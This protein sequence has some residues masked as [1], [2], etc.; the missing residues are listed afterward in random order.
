MQDHLRNRSRI[1][2]LAAFVACPSMLVA[3]SYGTAGVQ[4]AAVGQQSAQAEVWCQ[5]LE[6]EVPANLYAEMDCGSATGVARSAVADNRITNRFSL[7]DLFV[8][9]PQ[10]L[11]DLRDDSDEDGPD[12]PRPI[13]SNENDPDTPST[14]TA[15]NSVGKWDRL[16][17]LGVTSGNLQNQSP[18]FH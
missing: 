8:R 6:T 9:R 4:D 18:E 10:P 3:G 16:S 2:A 11:P 14:P 13:A 1:I 7:R 15:S 17:E 12:R 5:K